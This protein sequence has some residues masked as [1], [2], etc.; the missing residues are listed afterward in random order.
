M[1]VRLND[2]WMLMLVFVMFRRGHVMVHL[3]L[4]AR[5]SKHY[6]LYGTNSALRT[7]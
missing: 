5:S 1:C 6:T 3:K 2:L 4:P 7:Q